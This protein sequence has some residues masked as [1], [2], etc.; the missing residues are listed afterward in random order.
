LISFRYHIVS[1]M[2]VFLALGLGILLGSSVVSAPL[3][4]QHV[5]D[6]QRYKDE[7]DDAKTQASKVGAENDAL[8]RRLSEE[9]APWAVNQRLVDLPFVFVSDGPAPKWRGHVE[10]ALVAAGAK[11][12]GTII[13]TERWRFAA[14]EDER[15][16]LSSVTSVI[17]NFDPKNDAAASALG[18]VGER[19]LEP[20]G[21]ALVDVLTRDGF[22]TVQ[23]GSGN[24]W[25]PANVAVVVL[26]AAGPVDTKP[27]PGLLSFVRNVAD[28]TPALATSDT[29]DRPSIVSVL[30]DESSLADTLATFDS[31]TNEG[32]PGGI[33]VVAALE[34]A[35]DG[36]GGH[37]GAERGRTFVAPPGPPE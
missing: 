8:K 33:G 31:A 2:A 7:R 23:G 9:I 12:Q 29:P 36:R 24:D 35:R 30:R 10:D 21:R 5:A 22:I 11:P 19:F 28:A 20:T 1:I 37:F 3:D 32:D 18:T 26:S 4:A 13:L 25:P 6:A 34:A 17:P 14:P 27:T 15:D 16:L